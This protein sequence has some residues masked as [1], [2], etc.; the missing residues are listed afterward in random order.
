LLLLAFTTF[1]II[2]N[3]SE[4]GAFFKSLKTAG[5]SPKKSKGSNELAKKNSVKLLVSSLLSRTLSLPPPFLLSRGARARDHPLARKPKNK[6]R[7]PNPWCVSGS[8]SVFGECSHFDDEKY[9]DLLWAI[10]FLLWSLIL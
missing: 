9:G 6:R 8:V 10:F 4:R 7:K 1:A 2:S 3:N 5:N